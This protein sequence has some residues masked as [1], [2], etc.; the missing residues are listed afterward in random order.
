[1]A[2]KRRVCIIG[3]GATGVALLWTLSQNEK[4]RREWDFTLLHNQPELGGHSLTYPVEHNG[5]TLM[6]ISACSSSRHC[7]TM[8]I[9]CSAPGIQIAGA[10]FQ[11][12]A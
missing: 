12:R 10:C 9:P 1:M 2:D 3:G 6:W 4:A 5:K 8:C 11:Y 7:S